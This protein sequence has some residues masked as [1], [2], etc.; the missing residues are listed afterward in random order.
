MGDQ[1]IN[2]NIFSNITSELISK[3]VN[4]C[5]GLWGRLAGRGDLAVNVVDRRNI[6]NLDQSRGTGNS[7]QRMLERRDVKVGVGGGRG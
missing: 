5:M 4:Q 7:K 2:N 6:E 1:D 3:S